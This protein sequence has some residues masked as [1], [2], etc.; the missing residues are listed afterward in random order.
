[1]PCVVFRDCILVLHAAF[2]YQ[3]K[4]IDLCQL[5]ASV[6]PHCPSPDE[7][8]TLMASTPSGR[9]ISWLYS[10]CVVR[11]RRQALCR[12][13]VQGLLFWVTGDLNL[14]KLKVELFIGEAVVAS[15]SVAVSSVMTRG[16]K[17]CSEKLRSKPS[18]IICFYT[19]LLCSKYPP[20]VIGWA[21][22]WRCHM[23][24]SERPVGVNS[25]TT[26]KNRAEKAALLEAAAGKTQTQRD[27]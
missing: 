27:Y 3:R 24:R 25:T 1:M 20:M 15:F 9:A 22:R 23:W 8:V 10:L 12:L 16:G 6:C 17:Y 19:L 21:A 18:Q 5:C 4:F 13:E 26:R 14:S 2:H 11:L 7:G